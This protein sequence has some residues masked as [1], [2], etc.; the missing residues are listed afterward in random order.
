MKAIKEVAQEMVK[1]QIADDKNHGWGVEDSL[2]VIEA[3]VSQDAENKAEEKPDLALAKYTVGEDAMKWIKKMVNPSAFRQ[4][5]EKAKMLNASEGRKA[6]VEKL[7][8]TFDK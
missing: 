5:L 1:A 8:A 6:R 2:A 7:F 4:E 3:I